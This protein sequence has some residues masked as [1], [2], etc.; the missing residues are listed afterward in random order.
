[1][2]SVEE[3]RRDP[4]TAPIPI[5]PSRPP[6]AGASAPDWSREWSPSMPAHEQPRGPACA[7]LGAG[8]VGA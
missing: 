7:R 4:L 5:G 2:D 6:G 1:V 8:A 3:F